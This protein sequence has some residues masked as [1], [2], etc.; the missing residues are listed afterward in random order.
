MLDKEAFREELR[1]QR[2]KVAKMEEL[3]P[4]VTGDLSGTEGQYDHGSCQGCWNLEVW[5]AIPEYSRMSRET[6]RQPSWSGKRTWEDKHDRK[7][8]LEA[9]TRLEEFG[10]V[11]DL[12]T[13]RRPNPC[14]IPTLD[15]MFVSC[16]LFVVFPTATIK[17]VFSKLLFVLCVSLS[18]S[19]ILPQTHMD[20]I[21][22]EWRW[23]CIFWTDGSVGD[24]PMDS[25]HGGS[26]GE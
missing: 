11:E 20:P 6:S 2:L 26:H 10:D 5:N 24:G 3:Q 18:L 25:E 4:R 13:F 19:L 23:A 17:S 7:K 14:Y 15:A 8:P 9:W 22:D 16:H 21:E 1:N 12:L